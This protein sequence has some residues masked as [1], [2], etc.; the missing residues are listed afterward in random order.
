MAS[1]VIVAVAFI[2]PYFTGAYV[3][4]TLWLAFGSMLKLLSVALNSDA[5]NVMSLTC[6][7]FVPVFFS[8]NVFVY[9]LRIG[10][11]P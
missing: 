6:R 5:E 4:V 3:T 2:T 7:V 10:I 1:E 8:V 11:C 9:V